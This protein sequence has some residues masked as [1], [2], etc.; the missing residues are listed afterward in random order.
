VGN[1]A[2]AAC[3]AWSNESVQNVRLLGGMAPTCM[4]ESLAYDCR[5]MNEALRDGD[6]AARQLRD[7][8]VRGD[9]R[10]DPQ[11]YILAPASAMRLA[12][13]I[14]AEPNHYLAGRAVA[15]EAIAILHEAQQA[16]DLTLSDR[17][18]PWLA[19][20]QEEVAS[21]PDNED[22]FIDAMTSTLDPAHFAPMDCGR[23]E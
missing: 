8:L 19:S 7:W 21:L 2:A 15:A 14:V 6:V 13:R 9:T 17:E 3:D 23:G 22:A 5:L 18:L 11:A 4:L 1:V 16:G 20:M 12:R 10:L